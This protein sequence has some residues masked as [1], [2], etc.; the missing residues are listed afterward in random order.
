MKSNGSILRFALPVLLLSAGTTAQ[1]HQ[2]WYEKAGGDTLT[3]RYGELDK[4]MHEVSP[5]GLDRMVNL[6]TTLY[7]P[8]GERKIPLAKS[9]DRLDLPAGLKPGKDDSLVSVDLEYPM[10][11]IQ[12]NGES[13][14][15]FWIPATRWVGDFRKR[16][17][18]LTLDI[19]PT[20]ERKGD[21]Q[22]FRVTYLGE[23]L[24]GETVK[25]SV[26]SGWTKTATTDTD[27]KFHAALPWSGD[28]SINL[29]FIDDVEGV[30][31]LAG[32]PDEAYQTEGYNT[33]LSFQVAQGLQPLPVA[34]KMLSAS[35]LKA[36]GITPP[37][38]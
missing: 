7:S 31:K 21:E 34:E 18:V 19:V 37:K 8:K 36:M 23:P 24:A 16:E 15:N 35:E 33:T 22:E 4:N 20:G 10:H 27:G 38:H 28:Y 25:V 30:R 29:Y 1:A 17:P 6:T 14:H 11:D 26:P 5:G 3:L 12:R 32:R 2:F 13:K 9:R